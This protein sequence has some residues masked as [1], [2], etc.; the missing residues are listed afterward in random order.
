MENSERYAQLEAQVRTQKEKRANSRFERQ[1]SRDE[2]FAL[3]IDA[4]TGKSWELRLKILNG[5]ISIRKLVFMN[6]HREPRELLEKFAEALEQSGNFE[7]ALL[8]VFPQYAKFPARQA[9][10]LMR[11]AQEARK[12][13]N[14]EP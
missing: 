12:N 7:T 4:V 2:D 14:G 11:E 5:Q 10:K 3:S 13:P 8:E 6:L 1:Q 9:S